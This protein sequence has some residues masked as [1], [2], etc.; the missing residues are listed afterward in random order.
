MLRELIKAAENQNTVVFATHSVFMID[1]ENYDR[2]VIIKKEREQTVIQPSKKDRIGFFM[3]E[4]VLYSAL[5]VDL[6]SEFASRKLFNIVLEGNGDAMLFDCFYNKALRAS[7][8]PFDLNKT[9][10]YHG[11][12]CS[13]IKKYFSQKPIQLGATWVFILDRDRPANDLKTF[14]EGRYRDF[15]DK[16]IFVFQYDRDDLAD[17]EVEL[18]DLLPTEL[19]TEVFKSAAVQTGD[20][21]DFDGKVIAPHHFATYC[22]HITKSCNDAEEFKAVFKEKLNLRITDATKDVKKKEEL[23]QFAP[24]FS[25]WATKVMKHIK[26]SRLTPRPATTK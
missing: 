13:D 9:S 16:Y 20:T 3:Q 14:I 11:G 12:K 21:I 4:E 25:S 22:E 15:L 23:Q 8:R 6:T 5:D 2:H 26:D 24:E 7:D 10:I 19:L 18:E 1:K 17:K